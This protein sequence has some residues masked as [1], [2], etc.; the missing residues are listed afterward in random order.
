MVKAVGLAPAPR[1]VPVQPGSLIKELIHRNVVVRSAGIKD[2]G[3]ILPLAKKMNSVNLPN[4]EGILRRN[5]Q[6]SDDSFRRIRGKENDGRFQPGFFQFVAEE[7]APGAEAKAKPIGACNIAGMAGTK[8]N[9][10]LYYSLKDGALTLQQLPYQEGPTTFGGI[11]LDEPYRGNRFF[12]FSKFLSYARCWFL[13]RYSGVFR[14]PIFAEILPIK[15]DPPDRQNKFWSWAG[16]DKAKIALTYEQIT[17]QV[18]QRTRMLEAFMPKLIPLESMPTAVAQ[19]FDLAK[20]ESR[21]AQRNLQRVYF[22]HANRYY[23]VD[24]GIIVEAKL[25]DLIFWRSGMQAG[26]PRVCNNYFFD[27]IGLVGTTA[28]ETGQ[29]RLVLSP[30]SMVPGHPGYIYLPEEKTKALGFDRNDTPGI[31]HALPVPLYLFEP[32]FAGG[33]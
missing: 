23:V 33:K 4:A 24:A 19:E 2:L 21:P 10:Y 27:M 32:F 25:Q 1:V 3:A 11:I 8:E 16:M 9:P 18:H 17:R 31:V 28:P 30:Y 29:V 13:M 12:P 6:A 15:T 22:R 14:Y 5:L 7:T 20:K 26:Y